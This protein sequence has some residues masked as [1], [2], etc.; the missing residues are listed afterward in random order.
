[1][2]KVVFLADKGHIN[3]F[4]ISGHSSM[5]CDDQEGK[6]VCSAVSSA[7]YMAANTVTDIIRADA[8][9]TADDGAMTLL[10]NEPCAR[11]ET[12]LKGLELHLKELTKQY[13]ENIKII[14]G[15]VKNA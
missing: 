6:I 14:Y 10:V 1:M 13:P 11:T 7:A 9:A 2:T 4:K 8:E 15:G 3:G 5:D 12:V